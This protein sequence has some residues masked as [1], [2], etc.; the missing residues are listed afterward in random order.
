MAHKSLDGISAS[1][2]EALGIEREVAKSLHGRLT[3]IIRNYGTATPDTW[4]N[5]SRHILSPDLPF[6]FHQ[7]MYYGCYKD[8][9]P[10]P[11]A[12]IPDL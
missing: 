6:S 9:G 8:F 2:I 7:M 4:S 12:W 3:K 5:I 11:P 10:D 1:D